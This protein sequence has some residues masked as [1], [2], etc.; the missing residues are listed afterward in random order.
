M[1]MTNMVPQSLHLPLFLL[2]APSGKLSHLEESNANEIVV[3]LEQGL[4]RF[5]DAGGQ[6]VQTAGQVLYT[7]KTQL[8]GLWLLLSAIFLPSVTSYPFSN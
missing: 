1:G 5:V 2:E 7:I 4:A 3:Q 8:H 6:C